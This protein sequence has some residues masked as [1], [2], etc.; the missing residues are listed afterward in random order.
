MI[1]YVGPAAIWS[2]YE[3]KG[4]LIAAANGLFYALR[5]N[6]NNHRLPQVVVRDWRGAVRN[7]RQ[8]L[9]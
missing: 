7:L 1:G 6:E 5:R 3:G 2:P 4:V 8:N 9:S